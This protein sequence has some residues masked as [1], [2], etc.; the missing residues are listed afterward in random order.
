[1]IVSDHE[2]HVWLG[3]IQVLAKQ[4]HGGYV[5]IEL[6][7]VFARRPHEKLRRVNRP[8]AATIF[9]MMATSFP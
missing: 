2:R 4:A 6:R 7:G 8:M 1:V 3:L 5:G 9:P